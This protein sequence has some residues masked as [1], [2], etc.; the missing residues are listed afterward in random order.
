[1]ID[2]CFDQNGRVMDLSKGK[3]KSLISTSCFDFHYKK[4]NLSSH[5][6]FHQ[7]R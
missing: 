1:M 5:F 6:L 2:D 4:I 7:N 3:M